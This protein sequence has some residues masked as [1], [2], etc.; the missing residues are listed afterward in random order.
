MGKVYERCDT[1]EV[2]GPLY[3]AMR[4]WHSELIDAQVELDVLWCY[5]GKFRL[6][7][8]LTHQ[9]YS[10]AALIRITSLRERANGAGDAQLI[11]DEIIWK[12]STQAQRSAIFDHELEH[13]QISRDRLGGLKTDALG[14][15]KLKLK[16]HDIVVGGFSSIIHRH[17]HQAIEA[18]AIK[19]AV[20]SAR[21]VQL[22]FA[23]D[24]PV[25]DVSEIAARP[26]QEPAKAKA[27]SGGKAKSTLPKQAPASA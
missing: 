22:R 15:P 24:P 13:L 6:L 9:G 5:S 3:D 2:L 26:E 27:K 25:L 7:P 12:D 1:R 8:A 18:T 4:D 20:E 14:R 19:Q 17:K 11:L 23:W 21:A 16:K 10:A